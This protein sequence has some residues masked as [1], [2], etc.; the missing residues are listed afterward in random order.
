MT[1]NKLILGSLVL[2]LSSQAV[3]DTFVVEDIRM[4]GLQRVALGAALTYIPVRSGD[5]ISREDVRELIRQLYASNHFDDIQVEREGESLIVVV[6][7]RPTISKIEF[8][9]NKDLKEDQL[10]DS[11]RNTG[12]AEGESLDRSMTDG[13]SKSIEEFYHSVGKY[14]A[15]VT[16]KV[17]ELPRNRVE[18]RFDFEEGAAAEVAQINFIGNQ[19]FSRDE[20]LNQMELRD[21]VPWYGVLSKRNYQQ[22]Q[23]TGD[24]EKIESFYLNHGY[25]RYDLESVQ[26]AITPELEKIYITM[27]IEEGEQYDIQ[28]ITV[29]GDLQQHRE[30]VESVVNN[31]KGRR[32]NQAEITAFEDA[33]KRYFGRIGYARTQVETR[34]DIHNGENIVDLLIYVE[35]GKRVYVRNIHFDGNDDTRD[36][37]LRREMRQIEG[38]WLSDQLLEGGKVRLERLGFFE[39]VEVETIPVAG[40]DDLVD[41]VYTVKEQPAGTISASIGYGKGSGLTLNTAITQENFL[42]SGNQVGFD[43]SK[44]RFSKT[45]RVNYRDN[46]FTDDGVSLGGHVFLSE[47]DGAKANLQEFN[48]K[49]WGSGLDLGFPI[50]EY[51]RLALGL[52]YTST[53]ITQQ[54]QYDQIVK[55][56]EKYA[57]RSGKENQL[58][59]S[60]FYGSFTWSRI[61]LNRGVFP[62]SGTESIFSV[63]ATVPGS[64]LQYFKAEYR[65]RY[66]LPIDKS[67]D[68]VALLRLRAGYGN[69]YGKDGD[70]EYTLPFWENFYSGGEDS[71]RGFEQNRV[72][73]RGIR[74]VP[75]FI[76][77]PPDENGNPTNIA[78]GPEHDSIEVIRRSALGGN[79]MVNANFELIFPTPFASEESKNTVR[80]SAFLDVS[81]IW[82]TEFNYKDY[83]DLIYRGDVPFWDYGDPKKYQASYGVSVQWLSPMGALTFSFGFPLRS[84]DSE[85][86]DRFT[87][88][89][90]TTF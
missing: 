10:L 33:V 66:Y 73:P 57:S 3:A 42:G 76:Q 45:A 65:F 72:G 23:L 71:I 17:I 86:E 84:L 52:G 28:D 51:N 85:L 20:L 83:E 81:S 41:I 37:V 68:W 39:T 32:Y 1:L 69:G 77:G 5:K 40:E 19:V 80:T 48:Q 74:R 24:L 50:N 79:A 2:G 89:I 78:L 27:N 18:L 58:N 64:D 38:A 54:N 25:L 14:N 35:P 47:F 21:K 16:V 70:F 31:L 46:Y 7:E 62:T 55:F 82:D 30:W 36:E 59:F 63:K 6:R 8:K 11:L 9:G 13:L 87:F 4:R 56:Y 49:S 34:P 44:N 67:H 43:I 61:T 53:G 12:I 26:V 29:L 15:K 88:N 75:T 90:G 60:S 22:Q